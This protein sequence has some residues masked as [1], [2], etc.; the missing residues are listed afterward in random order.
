MRDRDFTK[1]SVTRR[2]AVFPVLLKS[3]DWPGF[4]SGGAD[5]RG[6]DAPFDRVG[7]R[8]APRHARM[9]LLEE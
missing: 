3:G 4:A 2:K 1:N 9:G 5:D 6:G 7:I 8:R